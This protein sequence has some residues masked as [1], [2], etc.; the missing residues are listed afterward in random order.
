MQTRGPG[1]QGFLVTRHFWNPKTRVFPRPKT[2]VFGF[3]LG[4]ILG[5][6]SHVKTT[7]CAQI[8]RKLRLQSLTINLLV[9]KS[10]PL[11]YESHKQLWLPPQ[12]VNYSILYTEVSPSHA[13]VYAPPWP[14][15]K[16]KSPI[17]T[18]WNRVGNCQVLTDLWNVSDI[19]AFVASGLLLCCGIYV[20]SIFD[21]SASLSHKL[22][23]NAKFGLAIHIWIHFLWDSEVLLNANEV[24]WVTI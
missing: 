18:S 7:K 15:G 16:C 10:P 5:D 22:A 6:I 12:H 23:W 17:V 3:G 1:A 9:T 11:C 4:S 19:L 13:F 24:N 2:R 14:T 20:R 21:I 8:S